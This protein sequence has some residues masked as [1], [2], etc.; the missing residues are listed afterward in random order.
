[1][2]TERIAKS[3]GRPPRTNGKCREST[4]DEALPRKG[5]STISEPDTSNALDVYSRVNRRKSRKPEPEQ[6]AEPQPCETCKSVHLDFDAEAKKAGLEVR[7]DGVVIHRTV[8]TFINASELRKLVLKGEAPKIEPVLLSVKESAAYLGTSTT[9]V[10]RL[11]WDG[12]LPVIRGGK[13]SPHR[14]RRTDLDRWIAMNVE[15]L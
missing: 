9:A 1:M 7:P 11:A 10:R 2:E 3:E 15:T 4:S 6:R 12:K 5:R 14:F 13:T 8:Q